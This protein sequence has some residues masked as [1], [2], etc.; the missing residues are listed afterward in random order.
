MAVQKVPLKMAKMLKDVSRT[1]SQDGRNWWYGIQIQHTNR[2]FHQNLC[3]ETAS[4]LGIKDFNNNVMLLSTYWFKTPIRVMKKTF[5]KT[6]TLCTFFWKGPFQSHPLHHIIQRQVTKLCVEYSWLPELMRSIPCG[7]TCGFP[8][9]S[10][11]ANN[12]ITIYM[13]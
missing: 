11:S 5:I 1:R 8:R 9:K 7:C 3:R 4:T 6:H 2:E 13:S 12:A 10:T